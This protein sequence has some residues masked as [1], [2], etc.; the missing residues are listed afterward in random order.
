MVGIILF[1]FIPIIANL[2]VSLTDMGLVGNMH[3]VGLKNYF[4]L[5]SDNTMFYSALKTTL[6]YTVFATP[7]LIT[8]PLVIALIANDKL[9]FNNFFK[10]FYFMPIVVSGPAIACIFVFIYDRDFGLLNQYLGLLGKVA[11][12]GN[13]RYTV[14]AMVLL[15]IWH[16]T[17]LNFILYIAA[18]QDVPQDMIEAS[19]IDG[20]G[21]MKRFFN[22][23]LPLISP[24]IFLTMAT[25]LTFNLK[26]F[27]YPIMLNEGR[28]GSATLAVNIYKTGFEFGKFGYSAAMAMVFSI[29]TLAFMT[30]QWKMQSKWVHYGY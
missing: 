2:A 10:A 5:F 11:W 27:V 3:F 25:T 6:L 7:A 14:L 20:A 1:G 26:Q 23:T 18:L 28:F 15:A 13:E 17:P 21:L 4:E 12:I 8:I 29:I 24:T 30:F 22:V 19:I 16:Q 9:P